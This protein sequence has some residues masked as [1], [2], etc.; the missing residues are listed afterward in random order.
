MLRT[1]VLWNPKKKNVR[2]RLI[3]LQLVPSRREKIARVEYLVANIFEHVAVEL[4]GSC[5][6]NDV[7][8]AAGLAAELC[9][10]V[11]RLH[12]EFLQYI[13][14]RERLIDIG[15]SVHV[16]RAI[17]LKVD[18][19]LPRSVAGERHGAWDG[20]VTALCRPIGRGVH[21]SAHKKRKRGGI[22]SVQRKIVYAPFLDNLL[23]GG[24]LKLNLRDISLY[25]D[26][27]R[28]G[29]EFETYIYR[30]RLI[31]NEHQMRLFIPAEACRLDTDSVFRGT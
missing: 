6:G 25:V 12:T 30:R 1:S 20:F 31:G 21:Y 22:A 19:I 11:A 26:R 13:G 2:L 10:V 16:L 17:E 8:R 7:H 27:L 14:K 28:C 9:A 23:Q 15:V 18:L 24:V 29:A 3:P 5:L 4:V